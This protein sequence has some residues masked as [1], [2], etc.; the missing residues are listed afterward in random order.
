[1]TN[2]DKRLKNDAEVREARLFLDSNPAFADGTCNGNV[3]PLI[4]G[5]GSVNLDGEFSSAQLKALAAYLERPAEDPAQD[6]VPQGMKAPKYMS[7]TMQRTSDARLN[8]FAAQLL[9]ESFADEPARFGDETVL[10]VARAHKG[11]PV[12]LLLSTRQPTKDQF[13]D[14]PT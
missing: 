10:I 14:W 9:A 8:P 11:T 2:E 1:M 12:F 6:G 7:S 13:N 5:E 3:G 4:R